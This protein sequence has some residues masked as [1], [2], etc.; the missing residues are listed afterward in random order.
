MSMSVRP[1]TCD[2][3]SE[4]I[5]AASSH[6]WKPFSFWQSP[7]FLSFQCHNCCM[8]VAWSSHYY[9]SLKTCRLDSQECFGP[10]HEVPSVLRCFPSLLSP[11]V[12][13]CALA[14]I[15][16]FSCLPLPLSSTLPHLFSIH[17]QQQCVPA[18]QPLFFTLCGRCSA[19]HFD[20]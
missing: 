13:V 10:E 15:H 3:G 18:I 14:S 19:K 11:C 16:S 4:M 9:V 2:D 5:A 12:Q 7:V 6:S 8:F 1:V 20:A 17:R